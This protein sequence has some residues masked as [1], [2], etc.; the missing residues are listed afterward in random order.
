MEGE[1]VVMR[2][3]CRIL[4]HPPPP[5][6]RAGGILEEGLGEGFTKGRTSV[7]VAR[8]YYAVAPRR[9]EG[10]AS[11]ELSGCPRVGKGWHTSALTGNIAPE[12][13]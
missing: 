5:L 4:R 1:R 13:L 12:W 10:V 6:A 9:K 2:E 8:V 11:Y 3:S 7:H